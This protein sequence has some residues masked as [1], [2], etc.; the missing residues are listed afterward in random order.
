MLCS[1]SLSALCWAAF[2]PD[3]QISAKLFMWFV[4][5]TLIAGPLFYIIRDRYLKWLYSVMASYG[6]NE[7]NEALLFAKCVDIY[8]ENKKRWNVLE[9]RI[10]EATSDIPI[11]IWKMRMMRIQMMLIPIRAHVKTAWNSFQANFKLKR[12]P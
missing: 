1:L 4:S 5:L 8:L 3:K 12:K 10:Q 6:T 2:Q 7:Q 9:E 11:M